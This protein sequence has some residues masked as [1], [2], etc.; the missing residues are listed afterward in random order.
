MPVEIKKTHVQDKHLGIIKEVIPYNAYSTPAVL[1]D[2]KIF[3]QGR[4][5]T[6]L[7][8]N[9]AELTDYK[10]NENN[11][12]TTLKADETSYVLNEEKYWGLQI[13]D[14]D[15]H[16]L[17]TEVEQYQVAKQTN[18]VVAPYL[19]KLRFATLIENTS[20]TVLT[21]GT[22]SETTAGKTVRTSYEAVI[23]AGVKL[24][25]L[26]NNGRRLL[27][28]TPTFY[29]S[30]KKE[31]VKLPQGDNT[32]D[33]LFKGVVGE[34]D[35]ALVIKVP[36]RILNTG[37]N[38][39]EAILTV[40]NVLVSPVQVDKFESGRLGAGKFGVFMQQ[41]LYTGAFVLQKNQAKIITIAKK[42][43]TAKKSGIKVTPKA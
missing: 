15:E 8:T 27:F 5:F 32:G 4:T 36:N 37:D 24:D 31:I 11:T 7:E 29:A 17:N 10:R 38:A 30:I 18:K 12:L 2:D 34:L 23:D 28:V 16:D 14:L 22:T 1:S 40:D 21:T 3:L 6:I 13:D 20:D 25:E 35:G 42:A 33:A 26:A 43:P 19:D 39:V 41:L 9:E